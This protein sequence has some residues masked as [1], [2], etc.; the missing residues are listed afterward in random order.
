ML[1]LL[2]KAK[3]V[4]KS[5]PLF[6]SVYRHRVSSFRAPFLLILQHH[7]IKSPSRIAAPVVTV[8]DERPTLLTPH[9]KTAGGVYRVM[10]LAMAAVPL[11]F[12]GDEVNDAL[13][14]PDDI[15]IGLDAI[16]KGY[17]VGLPN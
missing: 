3:N 11:S 7:I 5:P 8:R 14:D 13:V 1:W 9:V 4:P 10:L 2:K 12:L 6:L 17:P 16:F 15:S